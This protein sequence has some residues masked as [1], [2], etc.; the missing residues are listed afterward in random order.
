MKP[1]LPDQK[2]SLVFGPLVLV[3]MLGMGVQ[4]MLR[5]SPSESR[6]APLAAARIAMRT[7]PSDEIIPDIVDRITPAGTIIS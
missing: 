3:A 6:P 5:E 7:Q 4:A 1:L 2:F